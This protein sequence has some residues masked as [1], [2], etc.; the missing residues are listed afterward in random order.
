[1]SSEESDDADS[2]AESSTSA[3]V[4]RIRGLPWRSSRLQRF[5]GRL[6]E[7]ER[8]GRIQKSKRGIGKKER[9][10]GPDKE[11]FCMPPKGVATWMISKRWIN[12]SKRAH[13][14]LPAVL[15]TMAVDSPDF[16]GNQL[17]VLGEDSDDESLVVENS[18][19]QYPSTPEASSL[20]PVS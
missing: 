13:P 3:G 19:L 6:D 18:L 15:K 12:V 7:E 4:L 20:V 17:G 11:V 10:R 9:C 2:Q 8:L 1:M 14:D 5:Y 16:D